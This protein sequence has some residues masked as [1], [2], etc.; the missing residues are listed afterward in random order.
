MRSSSSE[1]VHGEVVTQLLVNAVRQDPTLEEALARQLQRSFTGDHL[2][3]LTRERLGS[4][5]IVA[6]AESRDAEKVRS[7]SEEETISS[8]AELETTASPPRHHQSFSLRTVR[9]GST[10][11]AICLA[12]SS[13]GAEHRGFRQHGGDTGPALELWIQWL[14]PLVDE[15]S[16]TLQL[17]C[18]SLA[19]LHPLFAAVRAL[20]GTARVLRI[21]QRVEKLRYD[22]GRLLSERIREAQE[23]TRQLGAGLA[24]HDEVRIEILEDLCRWV[25]QEVLGTSWHSTSDATAHP[26]LLSELFTHLRRALVGPPRPGAEAAMRLRETQRRF[27]D[28]ERMACRPKTWWKRKDLELGPRP[29]GTLSLLGRWSRLHRIGLDLQRQPELAPPDRVESTWLDTVAL[30]R[31]P[32]RKLLS[33]SSSP[34]SDQPLGGLYPFLTG[35]LALRLLDHIH[36]A[37]GPRGADRLLSAEMWRF[38]AHLAFVVREVLRLRVFGAEADFTFDPD[39]FLDALSSLVEQHAY[40]IV[41]LPRDYDLR[42]LLEDIRNPRHADDYPFAVGHLQH[43]LQVYCLA[44]FLLDLEFVSESSEEETK[45][46]HFHG[47]T[48]KQV[49][50]SRS[51]LEPGGQAV[52]ELQQAMSLAA[53]FHDAGMLLFPRYFFEPSHL[54]RGDCEVEEQL[55]RVE[56]AVADSA[57]GLVEACERALRE[58]DYFDPASEAALSGW[59]R[60]EAEAGHPDHSVLG[61]WYLHRVSAAVEDTP[62]EVMRQAVRA[63]LLHQVVTQPVDVSCDPVAALLILCDEVFDWLP[64]TRSRPLLVGWGGLGRHELDVRRGGSRARRIVLEDVSYNEDRGRWVLAQDGST[65]D[66]GWPRI[67]IRLQES[68][69]LDLPVYQLWLSMVQNLVRLK[70][71]ERDWA[72]RVQVE[73]TVPG[74]LDAARLTTFTALERLADSSQ[75]PFRS[76]LLSYL[77][78]STLRRHAGSGSES[79]EIRARG[80]AL[81]RESLVPF[82]ERLEEELQKVINAEA[83]ND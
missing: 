51:G 24:I 29:Q 60:R 50:A 32:L 65:R 54:A 47:W 83:A 25:A 9:I 48:V 34:E 38:R 10:T 82:F 13:P 59:V 53:L 5:T 27:R 78:E 11:S 39:A 74:A 66:F 75:L 1:S 44:H 31:E 45:R 26:R 80:S 12:E 42:A 61:A 18:R 28:Y 35:W 30:T 6:G 56:R 36:M 4:T 63:V 8:L 16:E 14:D 23:L 49:L 68:D 15:E 57:Q 17:F 2:R 37:G 52:H 81:W 70:P 69:H 46:P 55:R 43:A 64:S 40:R 41:D 3:V 19:D 67:S 77:R 7:L 79:I 20:K 71:S 22:R 58:A 72:P 73:G 62:R 21:Q 76:R 33:E